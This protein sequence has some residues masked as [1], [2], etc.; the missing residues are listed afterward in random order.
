MLVAVSAAILTL[1]ALIKVNLGTAE[2]PFIVPVA[3]FAVTSIAVLGLYLSFAIPIYLRWRQGD[4]FEVGQWNNGSKYK[5]MNP[6]AVAEILIVS[7]ALMMPTLKLGNPFFDGFAWKYVNY[8][9]IVTLGALIL[10]TIWW[11]VSVK[12]WF[13][14]PIH[15]IDDSVEKAL[16]GG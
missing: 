2:A 16:H 7:I 14:G 6:I 11:Q 10:L 15:N 4:A 12:H 3:F 8:S 13:K 9:G 1:P 5:W